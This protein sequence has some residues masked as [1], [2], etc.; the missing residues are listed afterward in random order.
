MNYTIESF[1]VGQR[2]QLHPATDFW[3]SGAKYGEITRLFPTS[4]IPLSIRL[5][6]TGKIVR[7]HPKNIIE[8]L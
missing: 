8:I 4:P 6:V 3:M 5:D 1:A 2:V 7:L